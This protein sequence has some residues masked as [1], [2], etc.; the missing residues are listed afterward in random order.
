MDEEKDNSHDETN[1]AHDDV[2]DAQEWVLP[3]KERSCWNDNTF[4]T[5]KLG[6]FV[7]WNIKFKT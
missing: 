1:T 4:G 2:G 3:A 7:G 6:H 5:R